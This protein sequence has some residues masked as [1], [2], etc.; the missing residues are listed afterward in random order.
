MRKAL[1]VFSLFAFLFAIAACEEPS[2]EL[3]D[4]E[5]V[6]AA[7]AALVID[8]DLSAVTENLTLVETGLHDVTIEWSSSNT[9]VISLNGTVNRGD[10][11]LTI[12]L[13][14][15]IM[16]NDAVATKEF[17]VTVLEAED[18]IIDLTQF[19]NL[20][21]TEDLLYW[22][23]TGSSGNLTGSV[24][25][26]GPGDTENHV[27]LSVNRTLG[28]AYDAKFR[29]RNKALEPGVYRLSFQAKAS[30][31]FGLVELTFG[32]FG[33]QS[34]AKDIYG[35]KN[36]PT[37]WTL[38]DQYYIEITEA[39]TDVTIEFG[40]GLGNPNGKTDPSDTTIPSTKFY[41]ADIT[42][43]EVDTYPGWL[44]L[45]PFQNLDFTSLEGWD[46]L[47]AG[48]RAGRITPVIVEGEPN[49]VDITLQNLP[50]EPVMAARWDAKFRQN[51]I[52]MEGGVYQLTF[53][54]K[55]D[56]ASKFNE[57]YV[58]F[59]GKRVTFTGL[60][61][62]FA[63]YEIWVDAT[64]QGNTHRFMLE[65]DLGLGLVNPEDVVVFSLRNIDIALEESL[66]DDI[67][68]QNAFDALD[69]G[70]TLNISAD[71]V[72]PTEAAGGVAIAWSSTDETILS[73]T[74]LF[75]EPAGSAFVTL[76]ATITKGEVELVKEFV[77]EWI[78]V[79]ITSFVIEEELL[80]NGN[81]A[82][83]EDL[84]GI[85]DG[86]EIFL[87]GTAATGTIEADETFGSVQKVTIDSG[88]SATW[89]LKFRQTGLT[90]A[91]DTYQV[92]FWANIS[93]E[94]NIRVVMG[95]PATNV[96]EVVLLRTGWHFYV[97]T[98]DVPEIASARLEF[99]LGGLDTGTDVWFADIS[100]GVPSE[101]LGNGDFSIADSE[102][103]LYLWQDLDANTTSEV[104][105]DD[106]YGQ[107]AM[108]TMIN[109]SNEFYHRKFRQSNLVWEADTTYVI[110]F[111]VK[112]D[113]EDQFRVFAGE[114]ANGMENQKYVRLVVD[115]TTE[116]QTVTLVFSPTVG[117]ASANA[118]FEFEIGKLIN[119]NILYIADV[120]IQVVDTQV[121][122]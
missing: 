51:Y 73:S 2:T 24:Q 111:D 47:P 116:W 115:V 33:G 16:L 19:L 64:A 17:E 97:V 10:E 21:F 110:T 105:A 42:F 57:L 87:G 41:L 92:S 101:Y 28:N 104:I 54:A 50:E 31:D 108:V 82:L 15:T 37:E 121:T 72:L 86:F 100:L 89:N 12:T 49:Q 85:A 7:K 61:E 55:V 23:F 90:Y 95:V 45:N 81:L 68:V 11:D 48:A 77:Y 66:P 109:N 34:P 99:E 76:T 1:L 122:E 117:S 6:D 56:D 98:L 60:S 112:A 25:E 43:E 5:K 39:A 3:T 74:G 119:G 59:G 113:Q 26:G 93:A 71:V 13:T 9:N 18:P 36:I 58:Y 79:T 20:G 8:G 22:D 102:D 53:E 35:L 70:N 4:Q 69:L 106:T 29:Q 78:S 107:I 94:Q 103:P 44:A 91:G 120:S 40:L 52:S 46:V 14:A 75:T 32:S 84:N 27:E 62:E 88:N 80:V 83:D 114:F 30:A 67:L 65:F 38:Y 63:T 96:N 118:R